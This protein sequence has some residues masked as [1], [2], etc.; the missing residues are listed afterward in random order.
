MNS[1]KRKTRQ[2]LETE[3]LDFRTGYGHRVI[4]KSMGF[5]S[6]ELSLP[7][8]AVVNS[9]SEQSPGHSHLRAISEGIKAG[10][11]MLVV[12]VIGPNIDPALSDFDKAMIASAFAALLYGRYSPLVNPARFELLHDLGVAHEVAEC[13][14]AKDHLVD[15]P[16]EIQAGQ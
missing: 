15:V 10:I 6:E 14:R 7:R 5:T 4:F 1:K 11:R 2:E 13:S 3:A 16:A 9:W 12:S 8:I